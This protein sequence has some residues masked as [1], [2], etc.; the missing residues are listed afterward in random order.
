MHRQRLILMRAPELPVESGHPHD[1]RVA[2]AA[3]TAVTL[4]PAHESDFTTLVEIW[5]RAVRATHHFLDESHI[6]AFRVGLAREWLPQTP[7][8]MVAR[9]AGH[10]ACGFV[11]VAENRVE[12]LFVDPV[13]HGQGVGSALLTHAVNAWNAREVDV[14][15]QN[16]QALQFYLRMGFEQF[17]RS[18]LDGM[19]LPFP[20]LHL[21]LPEGR[22]LPG[23]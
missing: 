11:G 8:L 15:E 16:P 7:L 14:N 10:S 19:G 4:H 13:M 18:L 12:M 21:R 22:R 23:S 1:A 9:C 6:Q 2:H 20:L 17:G 5:E 3:V